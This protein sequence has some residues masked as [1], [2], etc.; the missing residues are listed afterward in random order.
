VFNL[1]GYP[2][3]NIEKYKSLE[4]MIKIYVGVHDRLSDI[5]PYKVYN[6]ES[7]IIVC[8]WYYKW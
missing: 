3:Q 7:I 6:V 4:K 8:V 1:V 2:I 5:K